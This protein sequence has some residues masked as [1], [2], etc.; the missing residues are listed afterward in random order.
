MLGIIH[1][2]MKSSEPYMKI[3]SN[4]GFSDSRISVNNMS[5]VGYYLSGPLKED[6]SLAVGLLVNCF[7]HKKFTRLCLQRILGIKCVSTRSFLFTKTTW[8]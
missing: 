4:Y 3:F 5:S 6:I 7:I 8:S 2:D 1:E